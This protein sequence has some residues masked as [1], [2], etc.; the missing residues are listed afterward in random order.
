MTTI[1]RGYIMTP[2]QQRDVTRK[3]G[4]QNEIGIGAICNWPSNVLQR[5]QLTDKDAR[6]YIAFFTI[7][8]ACND[9]VAGPTLVDDHEILKSNVDQYKVCVGG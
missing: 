9:Y 8:N 1:T 4:K 7:R 2:R 5:Y 3:Q 6:P